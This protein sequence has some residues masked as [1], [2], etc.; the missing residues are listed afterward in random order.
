MKKSLCPPNQFRLATNTIW[1]DYEIR[2][3]YPMRTIQHFFSIAIALLLVQ[4]LAAQTRHIDRQNW[5]MG[6]VD[7]S[8]NTIISAEY[9]FLPWKYASRMVARKGDYR[10]VIDGA[11]KTLVPFEYQAIRLEKNGFSA[12]TRDKSGR[13]VWGLANPEGSLAL[14]LQFEYVAVVDTHLLAA[15]SFSSKELKIF[16]ARGKLHCTV[17]GAEAMP[18][19]DGQSV[20]IRRANRSTYWA[21]LQ[22]EVIAP[23]LFENTA[24]SDGAFFIR[25]NDDK[26]VGVANARGETVIPF[27]Y[28]DVDPQHQGHFSVTDSTYRNLLM[29]SSGRAL[30]QGEYVRWGQEPDAA[31]SKRWGIEYTSRVYDAAGT[32]LLDRCTV[33]P[34]LCAPGCEKL[35]ENNEQNYNWVESEDK[36]GWRALYYADGSQ[37]LPP[38]FNNIQ[39]CTDRHPLLAFALDKKARKYDG[40]IHDFQGKLLLEQRFA[41]INF[42]QDPRIFIAKTTHDGLWGFVD[43]RAPDEAEYLYNRV[44]QQPDGSYIGIKGAE[45]VPLSPA[46]EVKKVGEA[47]APPAPQPGF[48][49]VAP[50]DTPAESQFYDIN[51]VQKQPAF[52]GGENALLKYLGENLKYPAIAME[53]DVQG[54]VVIRFIVE[55]DG[56]INYPE[57]LRGIGNGCEQE[58]LRVVRAMPKWEPGLKDGKPVRVQFTLPVRFKLN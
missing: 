30:A 46:G 29:D 49:E 40:A 37:I 32:L 11:G 57:I 31:Y 33:Y 6:F 43:L 16:D 28:R 2:L 20:L 48:V 34:L 38:V 8:G 58:A 12:V 19:F 10:G 51:E 3:N 53:N 50:F 55:K 13:P 24:W 25:T 39:Y 44:D 36:P 35:P 26:G 52:P 21:N 41:A 56:R 54:V 1:E 14:P 18:G 27:R 42:T 5:K 4:P 23:P 7:A 22:G 15:R 17:E 45:Q 9:D 47:L